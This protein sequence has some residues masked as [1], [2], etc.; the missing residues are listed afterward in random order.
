MEPM[1]TW[2]ARPMSTV[3][4]GPEDDDDEDEGDGEDDM[5]TRTGTPIQLRPSRAGRCGRR[6]P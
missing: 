3:R 5:S 4:H 1:T 6:R 2:M